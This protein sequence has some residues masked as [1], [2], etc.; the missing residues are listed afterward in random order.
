MRENLNPLNMPQLCDRCGKQMTVEHALTHTKGGLVSIRPE[1]VSSEWCHLYGLSFSP[2]TVQRGSCIY[3]NVG[4]R[5]QAI[6]A[7]AAK[8]I[9][10]TAAAAANSGSNTTANFSK[11]AH[12]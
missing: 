12:S 5:D 10:A 1:D 9:A 11:Q 6:V 8:P 3:I 7:A 2:S 4:C